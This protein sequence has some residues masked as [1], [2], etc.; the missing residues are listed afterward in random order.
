MV[1]IISQKS[2]ANQIERS[3]NPLVLA[4]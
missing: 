2:F 4:V 3:F 1:L